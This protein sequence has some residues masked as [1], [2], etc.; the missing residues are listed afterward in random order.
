MDRNDGVDKSRRMFFLKS[1]ATT[2]L[3]AAAPLAGCAIAPAEKA[4]AAK[5]PPQRLVY[6]SPEEAKAVEAIVDTFVPRDEVGPG[7][8]E[9]GVVGFIDRRLAGG[10]GVHA[11][12]FMAGPYGP[13][14][15][16][17]GLQSALVPRET[18]RLGLAD[19]QAHCLRNRGN[20]R[21]E[22][23]PYAERNAVLHEV[24]DGKL[25]FASIPARAWLSQVFND[26]MDGYFCDPIHGGNAGMGS[27]KMIGF[28][29]PFRI[30]TQE[31]EKHRDRKFVDA[32]R[33]IADLT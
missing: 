30:Y 31:I 12:F 14:S 19:L 28:P 13:G 32:P 7:A 26:T 25:D 33:G 18:W 3:A 6:F 20:R 22:A 10:Y 1:G 27:W 5:T 9:L 29:G 16:E 4:E 11:T 8:V 23:L 21:F 15:A 24:R 2:A 17:Q